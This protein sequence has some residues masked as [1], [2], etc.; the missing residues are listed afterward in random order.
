MEIKALYKI[1]EII[2]DPDLFITLTDFIF[3][4]FP[5][6]KKDMK[7]NKAS[8]EWWD[9]SFAFEGKITEY[10]LDEFYQLVTHPLEVNKEEET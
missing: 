4:Q 9:A 1:R 3:D 7:N 5:V 2:G 8:D 10:T 6:G